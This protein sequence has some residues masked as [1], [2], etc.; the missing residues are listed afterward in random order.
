MK[1]S[2]FNVVEYISRE[3]KVTVDGEKIV[4]TNIG[5]IFY[6]RFSLAI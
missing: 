4:V 2:N 6:K 3:K 5:L 1:D